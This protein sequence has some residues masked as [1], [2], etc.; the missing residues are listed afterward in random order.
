ML[1]K[2]AS[3]V[4]KDL[5]DLYM[6]LGAVSSAYQLYERLE[7]WEEAIVCLIQSDRAGAAMDMI[8]KQ[9]AANETPNL[10]CLLGDLTQVRQKTL[11]TV[12]YQ[13]FRDWRLLLRAQNL[14]VSRNLC[15][16][17]NITSKHGSFRTTAVRGRCGPWAGTT[18]PRKSTPK[19]S[20]VIKHP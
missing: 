2:L 18:R 16:N 6:S 13:L 17:R 4:Q 5:C 12:S 15:R 10:W 1:N 20:N 11:L 14:A 7:M 9:L 19:P 8:K 3:C